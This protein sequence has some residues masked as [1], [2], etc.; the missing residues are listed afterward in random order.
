MNARY[1]I[2]TCFSYLRII[3]VYLHD[4]F[5]LGFNWPHSYYWFS[6]YGIRVFRKDTRS[7]TMVLH[8]S[9]KFDIAAIVLAEVKHYI[10]T[11]TVLEP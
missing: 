10:Q 8:V 1:T 3:I 2:G 4:R 5:G 11:G 7:N 6:I 9:S